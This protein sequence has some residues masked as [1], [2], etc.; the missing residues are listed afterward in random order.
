MQCKK[1]KKNKKGIK[2]WKKVF[3]VTITGL[4]VVT[5]SYSL[6]TKAKLNSVSFNQDNIKLITDY[7]GQKNGNVL[8][9]LN[10]SQGINLNPAFY[11]KS[12]P[13]YIADECNIPLINLA[14]L[15]FNKT[16]HI[17]KMFC[18]NISYGDVKKMNSLGAKEAFS[19]ISKD[20]KLP[21]DIGFAAKLFCDEPDADD[22]KLNINDTLKNSEEPIILYFSGANDLMRQLYNNP[23]AIRVHNDDGSIN[24]NF[25]YSLAKANHP[26]TIN[27]IMTGIENNFK[28]IYSLNKNS[29]IYA[30]SIYIPKMI[31]N[32]DMAP[33][34]KTIVDYNISLEKLCQQ[35]EVTYIST[36]IIGKTYNNS[37][38]DFHISELGHKILANEVIDVI[39]KNIDKKAEI[40]C[41]KGK[42]IDGLQGIAEELKKDSLALK[43]EK[44][45]GI[46][47]RILK[48]VTDENKDEIM[49]EA[50]IV[51]QA[52]KETQAIYTKKIK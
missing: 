2:L 36:E 12:F 9:A 19:K 7:Y 6:L 35:Y 32:E 4:G 29:K 16:N 51:A 42:P 11:E 22:Y 50:D 10:D 52:A 40:F 48:N 24:E 3:V 26:D 8:V 31:D 34:T 27:T 39:S 28:N 47:D 37:D 23:G 33:F 25:I 43:E 15:K 21:I 20:L 45:L 49:G 14:S 5:G 18:A 17:D 41:E 46:D 44:Y 1:I 30:L 13:E 38:L